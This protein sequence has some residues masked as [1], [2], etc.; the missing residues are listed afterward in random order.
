VFVAC[1]LLPLFG[2]LKIFNILL[3]LNSV[4]FISMW[5]HYDKASVCALLDLV[6]SACS[7]SSRD[8]TKLRLFGLALFTKCGGTVIWNGLARWGELRAQLFTT[9]A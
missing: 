2:K 9:F 6:Y 3:Q 8:T 4:E 7:P 5:T 1:I